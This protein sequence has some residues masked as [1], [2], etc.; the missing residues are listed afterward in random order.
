MSATS[1][2]EP[3]F[4]AWVEGGVQGIGFR[5]FVAQGAKRLGVRGV[6]RNLPD[7]GVHVCARGSRAAL[8]SLLAMLRQG[9]RM[10]R[11][12]GV[13]VDWDAPC[14]DVEDFEI[15]GY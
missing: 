6:V 5:Y 12:E 2:S 3:T 14:P 11:V 1:Q 13:K 15:V 4:Q 9:P 8:E 7:G 10:A